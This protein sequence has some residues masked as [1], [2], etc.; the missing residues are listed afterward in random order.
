MHQLARAVRFARHAALATVV[1]GASLAQAVQFTYLDPSFQQEIYTGPLVGGP[2]MVW[3]SGGNLLTR[4]GSDIIE[5]SP[6][7]NAVHQG[8]N[9]HAAINTHNI[10]GLISTGYGITSGTDGY[11]YTNT[12]NGLQRIDPSTW[13]V[14]TPFANLPG[15][16]AIGLSGGYGATTLPDGRIVY[17]AGWLTNEVYFYNP[18]LAINTLVFTAAGLIDDIQASPTGEIALAG[19]GLNNVQ[20]ITSAGVLLNTINTLAY[21]DGLAFGFGASAYRLYSNDNQG[22]ITEYDFGGNYGNA[23][24]LTT[25]ASG[26]SYGDLASVGPDCAL[27]VSQV[28]NN[29]FHG[30]ASF[31]TRW[32]NGNVNN[33][34]S[35]VR[36][37]SSQRGECAFSGPPNGVPE[38]GSLMLALLALLAL[39]T[40]YV[41]ADRQSLTRRG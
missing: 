18:G 20:I 15:I 21:P 41:R 33:D 30:S 31:G 16:G 39:T 26:G 9:I 23:P 12:G 10:A 37:S 2:G 7:Q 5:Y 13:T 36:I 25:I 24:T 22:T 3:T 35:I 1:L 11:L 40:C 17:V 29:N 14:T 28:Y 19:Q 32:D 38:P 34:P 6:T 4:N 27:Y 8:T